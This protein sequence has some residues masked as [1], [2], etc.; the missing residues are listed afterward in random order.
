[1]ARSEDKTKHDVSAATG[2]NAPAAPSAAGDIARFLGEVRAMAPA[3]AGVGRGRLAFALDAT[4]SREPTWALACE[5]QADMFAAAAAHGGL[6]MQIVYYRGMDEC[7]ASPFVGDGATL[8]R[9]MGRIACEGGLT[10][11]HRVLGHLEREAERCGLKAAVFVGDALEEDADA[12]HAAA[13]QLALRGVRL[14]MFQ[15]GDDR[16]VERTFRALAKL[17]GGAYCR[18]DARAGHHLRALLSAVAAYAAGGRPALE[19]RGDAGARQ[20]L[21]AL[22]GS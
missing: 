5:I 9:L 2:V 20:L 14:F 15:E 4:A 18:F 17:T 8:R 10:Q 12:L 19:A 13:G 21:L 1:M 16:R 11:I 3:R 6:D 7:R 22:G